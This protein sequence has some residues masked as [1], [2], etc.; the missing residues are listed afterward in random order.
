MF[1]FVNMR[2]YATMCYMLFRLRSRNNL[3][4]YE[5]VETLADG[6]CLYRSIWKCLFGTDEK[7][8]LLKMESILYL[9]FHA[10]NIVNM[11]SPIRSE[12]KVFFNLKL[13]P[14]AYYEQNIS[15]FYPPS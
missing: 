11:V 3:Y 9:S 4:G 7:W 1:T 6:N 2:Y 8:L 14:V 15:K 13:K 10:K 12:F 5:P